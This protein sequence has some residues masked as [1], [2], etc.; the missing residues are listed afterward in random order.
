M[1]KTVQGFPN[2]TNAMNPK[3]R[4]QAEDPKNGIDFKVWTQEKSQVN[5]ESECSYN[6]G[7]YV[8]SMRASGGKCYTYM[9]AKRVC[10]MIAYKEHPET[11]SY[12]WEY[13]G[14]CYDDGEIAV[15]EKAIPGEEYHFDSIPIEIREDESLYVAFENAG[16]QVDSALSPIFYFLSTISLLLALISGILF[17]VFFFRAWKESQMGDRMKH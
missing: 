16:A 11:A 3:Y 12:T 9:V 13:R 8:P 2:C 4:W 14:G 17:A 15:Y 10:L 5:T 7:I 1:Y 6:G